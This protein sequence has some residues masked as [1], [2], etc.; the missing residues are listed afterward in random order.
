MVNGGDASVAGDSGGGDAFGVRDCGMW[1]FG[2]Q[3]VDDERECVTEHVDHGTA[4]DEHHEHDEQHDVDDN[5]HD[6]QPP[7]SAQAHAGGER[8]RV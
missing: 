4:D 5:H 2:S 6:P 8:G 1:H 3:H 7:A